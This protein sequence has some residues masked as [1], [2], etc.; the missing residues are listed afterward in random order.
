MCIARTLISCAKRTIHVV[1]LASI[2]ENFFN[3]SCIRPI[4][5]FTF[6]DIVNIYAKI[7]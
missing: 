5:Q 1:V 3:Q 7:P 4:K 6:Y 2:Q